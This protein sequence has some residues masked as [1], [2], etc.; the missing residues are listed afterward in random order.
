[1]SDPNAL[2][3]SLPKPKIKALQF[4]KTM[5][6]R[7]GFVRDVQVSYDAK[8]E[9]V[10]VRASTPEG[11][12]A[13]AVLSNCCILNDTLSI[14]PTSLDNQ[15]SSQ[16]AD[17]AETFHGANKTPSKKS[18]NAGTDFVKSV[19]RFARQHDFGSVI[20]VTDFMTPC[21][22]KHMHS[23]GDLFL[24]HFTYAEVCRGCPVDNIHQPQSACPLSPQARVAFCRRF[25]DW[26]ASLMQVPIDDPLIKYHGFRKGAIVRLV[27]ADEQTGKV[28]EFVLVVES[29]KVLGLT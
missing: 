5:L 10:Q 6:C 13:L 18:K 22:S 24:Q 16:M 25:P 27:D 23:V 1:M 19:V 4:V 20:V 12:N 15:H 7:R 8:H 3:L 29:R 11:E 9:L 21:A 17:S 14:L 26:K 2:P 28:E